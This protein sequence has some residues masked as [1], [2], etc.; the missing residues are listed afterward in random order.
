[1]KNEIVFLV[2]IPLITSVISG[3]F[4]QRVNAALAQF[5]TC[6]GMAISSFLSLIIFYNII[7]KGYNYN[8]VEL[9]R[10]IEINELVV[11]WALKVDALTAVMLVVVTVVS[12]LV[13]VYSVG[14]MHDDQHKPRFMSYLSLFTFFMLML[15]T[16]D[17]FL[18][19]FLGWE[20]VGLCSY[21]LIGFWYQKNSAN[22]AAMKAFIVNRVGDFG[23]ILGIFSIY[24]IFNSL[25]F[26]QIFKLVNEY[27][28]K[29]F[30]ILGYNI[31]AIEI[32]CML[33]FIGCMGK[34]AQLGLH[35]WLPDAME[36]PT[37]VSALIHA[38]TMVT[39][40]VFLLVRCSWLFQYAPIVLYIITV[41]GALTCIF[42]ATIALT[43]NDIKKII[44]YS[45]CSQLGY[46]FFACGVS[47]YNV[48]LFHLAT[49]AFFKALLFLGAGSVIHA[50]S[51]E[52]DIN[53]M[54]G[55]WR[56]IP[57]TY[58][59]MWIGSLALAG[60]YPFAGYYSKDMIIEAAYLSPSE[61]GRFAYWIGISAAFC[62]AFY[63]WR[64]LI[65]VF[66]GKFKNEPTVWKRVHESPLFMTIP[67]F[68]LS[69]GAI[70]SGIIG[71]KLHIVDNTNKFWHGAIEIFHSHSHHIPVLYK[72]MPMGVGILGIVIAVIYYVVF[73]VLP[74]ITKSTISP[75]YN[76]SYYKYY[77]DE[78]Y[79][80]IVIK[81]I[82]CLSVVLWKK[83]DNVII[84]GLGPN[85]VVKIINL[86]STKVTKMQ[87]GYLYH[88]A[89]I[90][91]GAVM[92]LTSWYIFNIIN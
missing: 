74:D 20:G 39:A 37:P 14:Y 50:M 92:V 47:A 57:F 5:L 1:M 40:G 56:K 59:M 13:H 63:S 18:Q 62:T 32:S 64:L 17:N 31:S 34:S 45:T 9:L 24:L 51:G 79:E 3:L 38:A 23:F 77:W 52:Q 75:L 29:T 12:F 11:N 41:I 36:G 48:A 66:H 7:I 91:L 46:M 35:I 33:L 19:L 54:G 65:K 49:H 87:T 82:R 2:F 16:S 67:L 53:K 6:I 43:Q 55:I 8:T 81:P 60:I 72:F 61:S 27:S 68:I 86:L 21:L 73:K 80:Y 26:D 30:N 28:Y 78:I 42:A 89:Y 44:A 25:Q 83:I 70:F 88:Y 84:D 58:L 85:G 71:E 10:W 4:M 22:L 69:L 76:L 15:V 90:M